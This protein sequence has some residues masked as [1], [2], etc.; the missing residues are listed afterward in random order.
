M[1]DYKKMYHTLFNKI[2]DIIDELQVVQQQTEEMFI[3][4]EEQIINY[5]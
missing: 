2:T 3:A 4:Q 1:A 5:K